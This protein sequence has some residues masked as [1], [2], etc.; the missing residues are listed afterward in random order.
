M[1]HKVL[2]QFIKFYKLLFSWKRPSCRYIPTCSTYAIEALKKYGLLKG[3]YMSIKRI[4][5]CRPGF[6]SFSNC[7]YDPVP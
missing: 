1:L 2:I 7:G 4:L 6:K 5:R 3:S